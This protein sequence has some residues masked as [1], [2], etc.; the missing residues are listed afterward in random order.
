M[1]WPHFIRFLTLSAGTIA[2]LVF[3]FVLVLDPYQN[4]PFSP[5]LARAPVS[6]NQ[7]FAYPALARDPTFD[8][9]IIGTSTSR[10]LDPERLNALLN[11]RFVSLAM[12]SATAYEQL[13]IHEVFARHHPNSAYLIVGVDETWCNRAS[14]IE[15]YTFRE[16]PEWMMDENRWNDLLYLFNDKALENA[17]R[18]YQLLNGSREPKYRNDGY[19]DYTREFRERDRGGLMNRLYGSGSREYVRAEVHPSSAHA[20]WSY[21]LLSDLMTLVMRAPNARVVLLLPPLHARYIA[22]IAEN[23][24]ECKA[25]LVS[26]FGSFGNVVILDYMYAS[27]LTENDANYWDPIHTTRDVARVLE[28]DLGRV[29]NSRHPQSPFARV[30]AGT[31]LAN[32]AP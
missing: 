7:R 14:T 5:P 18:M 24:S 29:L 28:T 23:M 10:L 15:N 30:L 4:V 1:S 12:N 25:R 19:R 8:S 11:A 26:M 31:F 13:R 9:A 6:S 22:G 2:L 21:P 27:A 3:A 16:F 32:E 17:V 20:D